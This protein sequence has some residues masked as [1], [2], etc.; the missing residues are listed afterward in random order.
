MRWEPAAALWGGVEGLD[1][2]RA[3]L[4]SL[5]AARSGTPL[6]LE[7]GR[8]QRAGVAALAAIHGWELIGVRLDLA[9]H[10]RVVEL[11]RRGS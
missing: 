5:D 11:C 2:Y 1:A 4:A 6:L 7:I 8:G 3:L 9:G 10:E